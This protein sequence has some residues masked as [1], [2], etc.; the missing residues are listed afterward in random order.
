MDLLKRLI[1][2][3]VG[4]ACVHCQ[5]TNPASNSNARTLATGGNEFVVTGGGNPPSGGSL[6]DIALAS[7]GTNT[8]GQANPQPVDSNQPPQTQPV[9][10]GNFVDAVNNLLSTGTSQMDPNVLTNLGLPTDQNVQN[11]GPQP[12]NQG[13]QIN[14]GQMLPNDPSV[15]TGLTGGVPLRDPNSVPLTDPNAG[16]VASRP[17]G[18]PNAIGGGVVQ[19]PVSDPNAIGG[20]VVFQVD[21]QSGMNRG[22]VIGDTAA[23]QYSS[24]GS[25]PQNFPDPNT[26]RN[27]VDPNVP[28]PGGSVFELTGQPQP[29]IYPTMP[30]AVNTIGPQEGPNAG[31]PLTIV[32][33]NGGGPLSIVNGN[34]G[35]PLSTVNGNG[36][37]PLSAIG[38]NGGGRLSAIGGNAGGPLGTVSGSARTGGPTGA[39]FG[40]TGTRPVDISLAGNTGSVGGQVMGAPPSGGILSTLKNNGMPGPGMPNGPLAALKASPGILNKPAPKNDMMEMLILTMLMGGGGEMNPALLAMAMGSMGGGNGMSALPLIM[41]MSGM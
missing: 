24:A 36:G 11:T 17:V 5:N 9:G 34:G 10:G 29:G 8:G 13:F 19:R 22:P 37:G 16:P 25:M 27:V 40:A 1:I 20:G 33:G 21:P 41:S 15:T 14:P 30:S 23:V 26:A 6:L 18:D 32:N 28:L 2:V 39:A 3:A 7:F 4:I 35:G 12:V 38:G 31:G